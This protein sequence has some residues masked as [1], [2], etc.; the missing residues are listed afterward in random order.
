[1]SSKKR[2]VWIVII[3]LGILVLTWF[4]FHI[5]NP[6][7]HSIDVVEFHKM[8]AS[9]IPTACGV[10]SWTMGPVEFDTGRFPIWERYHIIG[11]QLYKDYVSNRVR[12]AWGRPFFSDRYVFGQDRDSLVFVASGFDNKVCLI[13]VEPPLENTHLDKECLKIIQQR[14]KDIVN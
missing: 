12:I 2:Y 5:T 11:R 13:T 6:L 10:T 8:I 7:R 9:E 1:M 3:V 14:F 4:V